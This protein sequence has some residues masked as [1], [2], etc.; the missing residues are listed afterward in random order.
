MSGYHI[1][2]EHGDQTPRFT[3]H[4]DTNP[5]IRDVFSL[6]FGCVGYL[7]IQFHPPKGG[8]HMHS[9]SDKQLVLNHYGQAATWSIEGLNFSQYVQQRQ[10][11]V[12]AEDAKKEARKQRR[13]EY[14]AKNAAK[15]R[16]QSRIKM[17][18][19]RL[20]EFR[21]ARK[22]ARRKSD[23]LRPSNLSNAELAASEALVH[24]L[25]HK[26]ALAAMQM[27]EVSEDSTHEAGEE[28][29]EYSCPSIAAADVEVDEELAIDK[30][31]ACLVQQAQYTDA[32][33]SSSEDEDHVSEPDYEGASM[34]ATVASRIFS[35]SFSC[36]PTAGLHDQTPLVIRRRKRLHRLRLPSPM[37]NSPSL[38]PEGSMPSFYDTLWLALEKKHQ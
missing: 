36:E 7:K 24:M 10:A 30:E 22:A 25:Q 14:Y 2:G 16:E 6:Y 13:R 34:R 12:C 35:F 18:D 31:I 5:H 26:T 1:S 38:S 4:N 17:A 21:A 9:N 28:L 15:I 29:A 37:P 3:H 8:Q 33:P 32:L 27:E 11:S 19:K 20:V 23:T